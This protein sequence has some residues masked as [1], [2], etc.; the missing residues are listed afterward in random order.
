MANTGWFQVQ[1]VAERLGR[2]WATNYVSFD[3]FSEL[4]WT[5]SQSGLVASYHGNTLERYTS[6]QAHTGEVR[7][8]IVVDGGVVSLAPDQLNFISREGVHRS[9]FRPGSVPDLQCMAQAQPNRA[10]FFVAGLQ[11]SIMIADIARGRLIREVPVKQGVAV[12]KNSAMLCCGYT[13]G[14]VVLRDPNTLQTQ[15]TLDAHSCTI[16]DMDTSGYLLA[17]CGFSN[18]CGQ[19]VVD[20]YVKVYD[21]RTLRVVSLLQ[22]APGPALLKFL[23]NNSGHLGVVSQAGQFQIMDTQK[24]TVGGMYSYPVDMDGS[25]V[26]SFDVCSAGDIMVFGDSRGVLHHWATT[27][28]A[29]V[30]LESRE[31][32][33]ADPIS[34]PVSID[35]DDYTTPLTSILP[36]YLD[37][38]PLSFMPKAFTAP[39]SRPPQAISAEIQDNMKINDFVGYAP[40][41]GTRLRNQVEFTPMNRL[42]RQQKHAT[43][44]MDESDP[45]FPDAVPSLFHKKEIKY[46]RLGLEDFD[47]AKYNR[48]QF[49]SLEPHVPNAYCNAVLQALHFLG[50]FRDYILGHV[51][52]VEFCLSCELSFLFHMLDLANGENCQASNFIRAFSTMSQASALGLLLSGEEDN[53]NYAQLI[54]KF[55]RF[56]LQQVQQEMAA[57]PDHASLP[58]FFRMEQIMHSRCS[59]CGTET[60]QDTHSVMVDMIYPNQATTSSPSFATLLKESL[61]REDRAKVWCTRCQSYQPT[62]QSK[63]VTS[64]PQLLSINCSINKESDLKYWHHA[65]DAESFLPTALGIHL[66]PTNDL[67][68]VSQSFIATEKNKDATTET[69][70]PVNTDHSSTTAITIATNPNVATVANTNEITIATKEMGAGTV[71]VN[72][73][74]MSEDMQGEGP[75]PSTSPARSAC[76]M[77]YAAAVG[78]ARPKCAGPAPTVNVPAHSSMEGWVD[79]TVKGRKGGSPKEKTKEKKPKKPQKGEEPRKGAQYELVAVVAY[80]N[81]EIQGGNLVAQI[82]ISPSYFQRADMAANDNPWYLFND[83]AIGA[84]SAREAF[85]FNVNWKTPCLL[86]YAQVDLLDTPRNPPIFPTIDP[87]I[88]LDSTL[89]TAHNS[90][91]VKPP[92]PSMSLDT[93]PSKGYHVAIDA[94]FVALH[95]E[96]ASIRSDGTKTTIKPS[97][98]CLARVS[99]IH[100]EEPHLGAP[101]IDDYICT[102]E[103]I[104]DYLTQF[105]GIHPGDLD[106]TVSTKHLVTLKT[107]YLKLRCLA[108]RGVIF[109]GHGLKKDF[110]IINIHIP[111]SQV[112]DTVELFHLKWQRKI[113]LRFLAWYLLS[114]DIQADNH[115]SI[116][117]SCTAMYLYQ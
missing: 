108:D 9:T 37:E 20:A 55:N 91:I 53:T 33:M 68:I 62:L 75:H 45:R 104:V 58:D 87:K 97:Q 57:Q 30:N 96:E 22:F 16:S 18:R 47:F 99:V 43:S 36:P 10:S 24:T 80:V 103:P 41:P 81:N 8:V 7:Q 67:V 109:I 52:E 70:C 34:T 19:Y 35:I 50:P 44:E 71:K 79:A 82:K 93:L 1:T 28:N 105:S 65:E 46:S 15:Q 78:G 12:M 72:E 69:S 88:L 60:V 90:H 61:L 56:L 14:Q 113:S 111:R 98:L 51:C 107:T 76:S 5:G 39:Y 83:Y 26:T 110:R 101:F 64:L 85:N 32:V 42:R 4:L 74:F 73:G 94:E 49:G 13:N 77:N 84:L 95:K 63:T 92:H 27:E 25:L 29:N 66:T 59:Q 21:I 100:A 31:L 116:E 48:T 54:Q 11:E 117:D 86:Y 102:S 89:C 106:S 6:F 17:T 40:N 112:I 115:D 23:P 2:S 38:H 114:M 3:P